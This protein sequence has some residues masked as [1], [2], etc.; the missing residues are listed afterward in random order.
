VTGTTIK[1]IYARDIKGLNLSLPSEIEEQQKIAD[2][3]TAID[4]KLAAIDQQINQMETFKKGLL[5]QMFV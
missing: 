2:F 1:H 4:N 5:Q 3:L